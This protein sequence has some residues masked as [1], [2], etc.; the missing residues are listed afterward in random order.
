MKERPIRSPNCFWLTTSCRWMIIREPT[1]Y[2]QIT[3]EDISWLNPYSGTT[4][5]KNVLISKQKAQI[6][7][8]VS[9]SNKA[10]HGTKTITR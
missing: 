10:K 1:M 7:A 3:N 4:T 6:Y 9:V 5:T 8:R 2:P